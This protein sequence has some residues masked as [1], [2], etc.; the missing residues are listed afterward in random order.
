MHQ[1]DSFAGLNVA[2]TPCF[3]AVEN[4]GRKYEDSRGREVTCLI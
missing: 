3:I 2:K 1:A 4:E